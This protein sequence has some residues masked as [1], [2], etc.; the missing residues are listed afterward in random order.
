MAPPSRRLFSVRQSSQNRGLHH[1]RGARIRPNLPT[2]GGRVPWGF[3]ESR[4][5]RFYFEEVRRVFGW[6]KYRRIPQRPL[7]AGAIT[8]CVSNG[9][10]CDRAL[11]ASDEWESLS[12]VAPG[13]VLRV[14]SPAPGALN[15]TSTEKWQGGAKFLGIPRRISIRRL[16]DSKPSCVELGTAPT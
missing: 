14:L 5:P 13:R 1:E 2:G 12:S 16:P 15:S 6:R 9:A 4:T 11:A 8:F 3:P 10:T 7:P